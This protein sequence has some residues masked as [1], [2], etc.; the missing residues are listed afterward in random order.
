LATKSATRVYPSGSTPEP[1][2]HKEGRS[3]FSELIPV[4]A[5]F[6]R[7]WAV[8]DIFETQWL[9]GMTFGERECRD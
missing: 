4:G 9:H 3:Q 6:G 5:D 2:R 8:C 7:L 1:A